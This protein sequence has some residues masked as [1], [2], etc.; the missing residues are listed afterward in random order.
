[1]TDL[2]DLFLF[3]GMGIGLCGALFGWGVVLNGSYYIKRLKHYGYNIPQKKS[4]YPQGLRSLPCENVDRS[5]SEGWSSESVALAAFAWL[6][7]GIVSLIAAHIYTKYASLVKGL[8]E[9]GIAMMLL[10]VVCWIICGFV[11][12]RQRTRRKYRDD[13]ELDEE[14]GPQRKVRANL[15]EGISEIIIY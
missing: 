11:F 12:W 5:V 15:M 1:M 9:I 4:D 2:L 7:G 10:P 14:E 13:V 6:A 3:A 8:A